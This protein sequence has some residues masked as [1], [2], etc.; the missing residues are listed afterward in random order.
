MKQK[1]FLRLLVVLSVLFLGFG[2]AQAELSYEVVSARNFDERPLA[3]RAATDGSRLFVLTRDTK[4]HVLRSDN[5]VEG[6]LALEPG[7]E[8]FEVLPGNRHLALLN[9]EQKSL[10][11]VE[12]VFSAHAFSLEG[13]PIK[14]PEDAPVTIVVFD[15]FQCPYCA[16]LVPL[17]EEVLAAYPKEVRLVFKHFPLRS[18]SQARPA[19]IASMAAYRQGHFWPYHDLLF[20]NQRG[21]SDESYENFARELNLNL[22]KFAADMRDRAI[23]EKI[24]SDQREGSAAG[25][26]GTPSIFINGRLLEQRSLEG[27]KDAIEKALAGNR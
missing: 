3:M 20:K 12:L 11:I 27:F 1:A 5:S 23:E 9:P 25:V 16:R 22:E 8:S 26:R 18:H 13:S 24:I 21:L 17:L 6:T 2:M 19:A 14:G 4:L 10:K 7:V 15:D